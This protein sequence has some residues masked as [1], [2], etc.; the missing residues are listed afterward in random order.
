VERQNPPVPDE[1]RPPPGGALCGTPAAVGPEEAPPHKE[2]IAEVFK[3]MF[4]CGGHEKKVARLESVPLPI[5][6][7]NASPANHDVNLVLLVRRLFIWARWRPEFYVEGAALQNTDGALILAARDVRLS[8]GKTDH[9]ATIGRAHASLPAPP[10][11]PAPLPGPLGGLHT[12]E[13]R[14]AGP[15]SCSDLFGPLLAES[16]GPNQLINLARLRDI[17]EGNAAVGQLPL[18]TRNQL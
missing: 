9:T 10:N 2:V 5:V 3:S 15:V 17:A 1:E 12:T 6:K 16:Q 18:A 8:L 14:P 7:Q 11:A 13:S 4:G